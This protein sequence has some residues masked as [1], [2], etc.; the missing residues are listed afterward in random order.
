MKKHVN[1]TFP[2]PSVEIINAAPISFAT[3]SN[4]RVKQAVYIQQKATKD[5][6]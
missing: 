2:P 5:L 6:F 3:H 4:T 1:L